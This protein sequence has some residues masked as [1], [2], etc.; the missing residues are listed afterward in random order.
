MIVVAALALVAARLCA[1]DIEVLEEYGCP[2]SA[3]QLAC[4][5]RAPAAPEDAAVAATIAVLEASFS[6]R[7]AASI[8][9]GANRTCG[10]NHTADGPRTIRQAVNHRCSG[11]NVCSFILT[12]D[13]PASRAWGPGLVHIKYACISGPHVLRL[14]S[15]RAEVSVSEEGFLQSPGYPTVTV[16]ERACLWRL[17]AGRGQ[18][19]LLRVLDLSLRTR[20]DTEDACV[21]V[22]TVREGAADAEDGENADLVR[23]CGEPEDDLVVESDHGALDV[24]LTTRSLNAFPSRGVLIHY[25]G[26][27]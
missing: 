13:L 17:R 15:A 27:Y 21:D 2:D 20:A 19:L 1:A 4:R 16:G 22:L 25:K 8:F 9:L 3:L 14:C 23:E 7:D 11:N 6:A 18:R 24:N 5:A 12:N 26:E 10:A